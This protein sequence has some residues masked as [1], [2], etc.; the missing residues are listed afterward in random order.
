DRYGSY[1]NAGS[2]VDIAAPGSNIL[3]TYPTALGTSY[4]SMNGTS[5]ASPHIAAVAALL[6][7]A[8]KALTPDQIEAAMEQNAVDLGTKG[9]DK[10]YGNG[11]VDVVAALA[12]VAPVTT[13]PTT[14]PT[15][16]APVTTAPTTSAPVTTAPTTSAPVTK[17]PTTSA[18]VTTAPVTSAPVTTAPTAAPT[19]SAP[20]KLVTDYEAQVVALTNAQRTANGC[21]PLR[22]DDRLTAAARAHSADM[23][24]QGFFSHT[25]SNGS[26]FVVRVTQAG[27]PSPSAENIAYGYRTSQDVMTGWMNSS[28]HRANILNCS[29]VAVGVGLVFKA[30]GTTYWTQNFGRV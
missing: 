5:M 18:P 2:Y 4:K 17:A 28:G 7:A 6:K 20:T 9:F 1:S 16:S 27:Y 26:T 25:G 3:S 11:R 21:A 13:P 24:T 12:A 22:V 14:A 19:T 29:S 30:D 15:T 8:N 10:D 23:A